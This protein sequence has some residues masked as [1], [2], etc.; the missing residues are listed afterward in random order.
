MAQDGPEGAPMTTP[1][2][3]TPGQWLDALLTMP[4]S[5]N[6]VRRT[7]SALASSVVGMA[8]QVDRIDART[9][10]LVT[11][12]EAMRTALDELARGVDEAV[13]DIQSLLDRVE[14]GDTAAVAEIRQRAA[15]LRDAVPDLTPT[16]DPT[17]AQPIP[18]PEA[19]PTPT[20]DPDA[21]TPTN[22][23]GTTP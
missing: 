1:T 20:T 13:G 16:P 9:G 3:L 14:A 22:G 4:G 15:Q 6:E 23:G 21:G 19:D 11:M 18:T 8:T 7:M 5:L 12:T 17:P 2:P 10:E